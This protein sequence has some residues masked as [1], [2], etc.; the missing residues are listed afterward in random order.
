MS[1]CL[2]LLTRPSE[3]LPQEIIQ[4]QREQGHDVRVI[5]L[6]AP[7]PDYEAVLAEVFACDSVAVWN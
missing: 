7:E 6:G 5:D 2:H 3:P 1:A 4:K